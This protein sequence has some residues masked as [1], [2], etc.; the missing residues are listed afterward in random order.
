METSGEVEVIVETRGTSREEVKQSGVSPGAME[1]ETSSEI[2]IC[3]SG[4]LSNICAHDNGDKEAIS[5]AESSKDVH[6]S[7][8]GQSLDLL[9][10]DS[11]SF[12]SVSSVRAQVSA[13]EIVSGNALS[14][15]SNLD[16]LSLD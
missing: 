14:K 11:D 7:D 4:E 15:E 16:L 2:N 13:H 10:Q 12:V 8:S 6:T 9:D 5:D 1:I 3:S